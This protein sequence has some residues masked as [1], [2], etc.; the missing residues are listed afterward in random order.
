M[1]CIFGGFMNSAIC[2]KDHRY[3]KEFE[4]LP[5]DQGGY[6]RHV[7]CGCAYER[8]IKDASSNKPLADCSVLT[9]LPLSQ[10][11]TIRHRDAY[12]A[13]KAGYKAGLS[14]MHHPKI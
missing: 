1:N 4:S 13:Y 11:G 3:R 5:Y 6:G 8:G 12:E 14:L 9:Q 10:A 7:C 2:K